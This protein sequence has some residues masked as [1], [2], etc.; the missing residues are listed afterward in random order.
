M[1]VAAVLVALVAGALLGVRAGRARLRP[2][3]APAAP[4]GP[5]RDAVAAAL[6]ALL[7][8]VVLVDADENVVWSNPA[9]AALPVAT[10]GRLAPAL[11]G[12]A[13]SARRAGAAV[14]DD[15]E[16]PGR[17]VQVVATATRDHVAL[18]LDDTTDA[19]RVD[20]VRKDFVAN[21][22]HELKT[23]VGALS[24]LAEA[25]HDCGDDPDAV[26]RFADR[27][28][29]E[30]RRLSRLVQELIDLSRLEGAE[31][32]RNEPVLARDFLDEA[33]DRTRL[34]AAA[35]DIEVVVNVTD[36]ALAVLGDG[37]QLTTAVANLID[38]AVA[39]SP[40]GTRVGVTARRRG[41]DVEV[42]VTDQGIGIGAADRARVFE[43]FYR[44][45]PARSRETGGTGLGLAI[46]KH[47]ATSHGGR[48]EVWSV[49]GTG[50]TFTIT[51]PAAAAA[52]A[53]GAA[54]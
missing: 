4:A 3:E 7:T 53:P 17:A 50:S 41:H 36:P 32:R 44:V 24:L 51:L 40:T 14:V 37:A 42:A 52:L 21:V 12:L 38:N 20:A 30:S 39:Y 35:A 47:I 16:L 6:D 54:S 18:L 27:M 11:A 25:I 19:R 26:R 13:R 45:D 1:I 22:S 10:D 2:A 9:A 48:V 46:V 5:P 15:V 33:V 8:A 34:A 23:P 49:E 43:R 28:L 29:V 31:P